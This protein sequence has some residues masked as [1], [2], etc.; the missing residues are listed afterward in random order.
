MQRQF[1]IVFLGAL[2]ALAIKPFVYRMLG[3]QQAA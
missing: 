2:I 3:L 1:G